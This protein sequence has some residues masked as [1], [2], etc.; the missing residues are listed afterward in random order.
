M[1]CCLFDEL[2]PFPV[3]GDESLQGQN[4]SVLY[5]LM[6]ISGCCSL[7]VPLNCMLLESPHLSG[8]FEG[9]RLESFGLLCFL[10]MHVYNR[11]HQL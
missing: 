2:Y 7:P 11:Y 1:I 10:E 4:Q 3:G 8:S 6:F 9:H 5:A